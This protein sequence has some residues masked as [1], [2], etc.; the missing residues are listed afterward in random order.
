MAISR[1]TFLGVTV[2]AV[3]LTMARH[4]ADTGVP[5]NP[6]FHEVREGILLISGGIAQNS[7]SGYWEHPN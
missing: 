7:P 2:D 5:S 1:R 4:L 3:A 6:K